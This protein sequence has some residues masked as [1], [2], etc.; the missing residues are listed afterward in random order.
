MVTCC[1][2]V[3]VWAANAA[4]TA[5]AVWYVSTFV[6]VFAAASAAVVLLSGICVAV[7]ACY[8]VEPVHGSVVEL[9]PAPE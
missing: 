7:V 6:V 2:W 3:A 4:A 1:L 5:L 9:M 8:A